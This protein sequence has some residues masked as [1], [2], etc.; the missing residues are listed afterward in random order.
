MLRV[1]LAEDFPSHERAT[2]VANQL[3]IGK[4]VLTATVS[5]AGKPKLS[6]LGFYFYFDM[7]WGHGR[8]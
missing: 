7:A 1:E 8:V 2:D 6:Q 5:S 3:K 4:C